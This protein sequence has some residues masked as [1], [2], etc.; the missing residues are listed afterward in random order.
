MSVELLAI[1]KVIMISNNFQGCDIQVKRDC[2]IVVDAL[3]GIFKCS[4]GVI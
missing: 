4:W 1:Q 2:A 3:L